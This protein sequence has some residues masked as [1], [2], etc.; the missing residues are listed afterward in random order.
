MAIVCIKEGKSSSM[1]SFWKCSTIIYQHQIRC[2]ERIV[3][4]ISDALLY[5]LSMVAASAPLIAYCSS[6]HNIQL[7]S[8]PIIAQ[9]N[10]LCQFDNTAA[11]P[12]LHYMRYMLVA[13]AIP[14]GG[15]C[16]SCCPDLCNIIY[17]HTARDMLQSQMATTSSYGVQMTNHKVCQKA[18]IK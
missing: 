6:T 9:H 5:A 8:Y 4:C 10:K 3:N 15:A 17:H 16:S 1:L 7:R 2:Q 11:R 13:C 14:K 18:Y 12:H